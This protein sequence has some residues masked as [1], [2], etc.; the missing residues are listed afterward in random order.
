MQLL[1]GIALLLCTGEK[2]EPTAVTFEETGGGT[3]FYYSKNR[4]CDEQ[5]KNYVSGL[6]EIVKNSARY[7]QCIRSVLHYAIPACQGKLESR[8]DKVVFEIQTIQESSS[9]GSIVFNSSESFETHVRTILGDC[10]PDD[11]QMDVF[12]QIIVRA[13]LGVSPEETG[14]MEFLLKVVHFIGVAEDIHTVMPYPVLVWRLQKLGDF[15][16]AARSIAWITMFDREVA[17]R[18]KLMTFTEVRNIG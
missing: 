8:L 6:L 1:D 15:F 12:L 4:P 5:E 18:K 13:I 2:K 7:D 11:M 16:G 9:D 3:N 17:P 10:V 14:D